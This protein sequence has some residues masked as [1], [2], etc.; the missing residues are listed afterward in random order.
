MSGV[1]PSPAVTCH[2]VGDRH[3]PGATSEKRASWTAERRGAIDAQRRVIKF[4]NCPTG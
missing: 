4:K 1:L 3:R 2:L